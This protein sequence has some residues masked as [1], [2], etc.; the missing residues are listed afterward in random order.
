MDA[1]EAE[2]WRRIEEAEA[3]RP[4]GQKTIGEDTTAHNGGNRDGGLDDDA[5][6]MARRTKQAEN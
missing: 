5:G 1:M 2:M 4:Q 3:G 6:G